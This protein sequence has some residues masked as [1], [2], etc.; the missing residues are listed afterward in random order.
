MPR[1]EWPDLNTYF[2]FL[3]RLGD[4]ALYA[5][6]TDGAIRRDRIR[7]R[8]LELGWENKK[9]GYYRELPQTFGECF[10][11]AFGIPLSPTHNEET[12]PCEN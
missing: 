12:R 9:A 6:V 10:E 3:N 1:S 4:R 2:W 8:I 11:R 5:G 7:D